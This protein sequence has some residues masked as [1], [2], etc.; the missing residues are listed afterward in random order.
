MVKKKRRKKKE[1]ETASDAIAAA[2]L[3]LLPL[4]LSGKTKR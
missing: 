3:P 2:L 4:P 1:C